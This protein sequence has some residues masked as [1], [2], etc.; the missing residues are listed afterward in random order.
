MKYSLRSLMI[1]TLVGPPLLAMVIR[2]VWMLRG[3]GPFVLIGKCLVC[4]AAAVFVGFMVSFWIDFV[5]K[6]AIQLGWWS[7]RAAMPSSKA[8]APRIVRMNQDCR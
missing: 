4:L 5:C 7:G 2:L 1:A 3:E 8:P 6:R